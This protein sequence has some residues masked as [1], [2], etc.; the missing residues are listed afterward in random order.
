MM[1]SA[2]LQRVLL[3]ML[4]DEHF[5]KWILEK[6]EHLQSLNLDLPIN[7]WEMLSEVPL[8][9]YQADPY[10]SHRSLQALIRHFPFSFAID[11]WLE[12]DPKHALDFFRS[13][14]FH[15]GIQQRLGLVSQYFAFLKD[16]FQNHE[17]L[18]QHENPH[19]HQL[20]IM[21]DLLEFEWALYQQKQKKYQEISSSHLDR[22]TPD[23]AKHLVLKLNPN[24]SLIE[25]PNRLYH[26]W[27][28]FNQ[29]LSSVESTAHFQLLFQNQ[30]VITTLNLKENDLEDM[31]YLCI[32]KDLSIEEMPSALFHLLKSCQKQ[33]YYTAIF[34]TLMDQ[35]MTTTE[36]FEFISDWLESHL[37]YLE[38]DYY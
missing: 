37:L 33:Q 7:A 12:K 20:K 21:L 11:M 23:E 35:E 19:N 26:Q 2:Q 29:L 9:Y 3:R 24:L 32:D 28:Q 5:A 1:A 25:M 17:N 15:E 10:R 4:Y 13:Q 30:I 14:F 27:V 31:I 22:H 36:A 8:A 38:S 18:H 6:K 34:K 16:R